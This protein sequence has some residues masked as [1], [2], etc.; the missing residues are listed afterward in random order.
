MVADWIRGE[1]P[2]RQRIE[3]PLPHIELVRERL[4]EG[5]GLEGRGKQP[6]RLR[7]GTAAA[8]EAEVGDV[9]RGRRLRLVRLQGADEG[10]DV[11]MLSSSDEGVDVCVLSSSS[12]GVI[13]V[14]LFSDEGI[15]VCV[16]SSSGKGV[17]VLVSSFS[18]KGIDVRVLSCVGTL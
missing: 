9:V 2:P 6:F 4:G 1:P 7:I 8:E 5:L 16:L 15:N 10:V 18:G 17:D 14:L 11:R 13:C 3:P 12:E